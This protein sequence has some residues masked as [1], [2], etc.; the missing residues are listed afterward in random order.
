[1]RREGISQNR[2]TGPTRGL[3]GP[4]R[5]WL[6]RAAAYRDLAPAVEAELRQLADAIPDAVGPVRRGG[7]TTRES[8]ALLVEWRQRQRRH[9]SLFERRR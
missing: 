8:E 9:V 7:L 4:E 5:L 2:D 1:M 3:S 6:F